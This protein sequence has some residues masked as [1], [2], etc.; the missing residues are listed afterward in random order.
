MYPTYKMT[1][2]LAYATDEHPFAAG[3]VISD[4]FDWAE[5]KDGSEVHFFVMRL[6][7]PD[8]VKVKQFKDRYHQ[9]R[10]MWLWPW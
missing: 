7:E 1:P 4:E 5:D 10:A 3:Y 8:K 2:A 6:L 9:V